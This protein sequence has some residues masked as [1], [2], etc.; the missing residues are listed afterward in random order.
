MTVDV[1]I[2]DD[3]WTALERLAAVAVPAALAETVDGGLAWEVAV[4]GCDDARIAT[5]NADF[6][7][8][9]RPTNVLSWPSAERAPE[10]PGEL[11]PPPDTHD[12]EL[13]D[14][15]IAFET[16][17][18]EASEQ[19]K[20]FDAHVIHLLVH[21]TLHLLGYDHETEADALRMESLEVK[22][23]KELGLPDPYADA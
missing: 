1:L 20:T 9:P 8:K 21:A 3:R 12:P 10:V 2:E 18:R 16:C 15:A 22:I 19:G 17:A 7:G 6:R 11:P 4:L 14:I 23:L 5:L 13:G